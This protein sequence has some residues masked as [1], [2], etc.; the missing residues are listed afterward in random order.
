MRVGFIGLGVMGQ[1]MALNLAKA[2]NPLL[3]WNRTEDRTWPLLAAGARVA[4]SAAQV[5]ESTETVFLMLANGA[6]ID[7]VLE[8]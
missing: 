7:A 5:F 1:A 2:K 3:V 4:A 6:A 8:R